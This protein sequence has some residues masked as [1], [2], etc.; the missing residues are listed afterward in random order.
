M[1]SKGSQKKT[2]RGET[3]CGRKGSK[4]I[5]Y[6]KLKK[7]TAMG[8]WTEFHHEI[9]GGITEHPFQSQPT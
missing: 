1:I 4:P 6:V 8:G 2:N 5:N 9:Q 7:V 3:K